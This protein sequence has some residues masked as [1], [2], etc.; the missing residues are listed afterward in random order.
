MD[1]KHHEASLAIARAGRPLKFSARDYDSLLHEIGSAR[2]V[3]IGEASHG[4]HEFYRERACI[5]RRLIAEKD[6]CGV[7]AEADWPDA[8]RLNRFCQQQGTEQSATD[9]LGDFQRFPSW[10]WRNREVASFAEWLRCYNREN[11]KSAGFYGLDLYSLYGSAQA[12]LQYLDR[13]DPQA[14][15]RARFRYSCFEHFGEDPQAYGY[16]ASF[17]MDESC[18]QEAIDQ[19]VELECKAESSHALSR[20]DRESIFSAAQNARLVRDAEQ[21]HR[22]MFS[23]RVNSWN[24]RDTHMADTLDALLEHLGPRSRMVVWAHN[25][26][27]GDARATQM[28]KQGELNVGELARQRYG[29]E[30]YI[31][32][33]TTYD[34][35]VRAASDWDEPGERKNVRLA[36]A[37]SYEALFHASGMGNFLLHLRSDEATRRAL[38]GP[39]LERAIGVVYHPH[40]ERV[41]H[42]FEARLPEQFD[43][44]IHIDRTQAVAP[45]DDVAPVTLEYGPN[46]LPETFPFET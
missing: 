2:V 38:M 1:I 12:V 15:A 44:I 3:L 14:A 18:E 4:T 46:D 25:S 6:F 43:T 20:R 36:L 33:F 17:D 39:M 5:T 23:G 35:E 8:W 31:I 27:V 24:L 30:C 9:A 11:H 19:L 32:G 7:A 41:S 37:G 13:T 10:M 42:Y 26:H 29:S 16:A 21:Y 45:L 22:T 34:G 40:T 28:E